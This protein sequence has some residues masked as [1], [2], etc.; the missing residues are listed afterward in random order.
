MNVATAAALL[1]GTAFAL[2]LRTGGVDTPRQ[3]AAPPADP[4]AGARFACRIFIERQLHDPASAEWIDTPSWP[5]V[6]NADGS[7]G[8][9]A[10]YRA[11]NT[12]GALRLSHTTCIIRRS[13]T[14]WRL[15]KL[16]TTQ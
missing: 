10:R 9:G 7:L 5:V 1:I 3:T 11:K 4:H 13:G 12:F 14:D 16:A 15:E 2:S 6:D 8:I